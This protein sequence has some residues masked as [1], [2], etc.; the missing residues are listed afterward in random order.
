MERCKQSKKLDLFSEEQKNIYE[1]M[2]PYLNE[3]KLL[4]GEHLFLNK[5]EINDIYI[6]KTG[7]VVVYGIDK[8]FDEKIYFVLCNGSFVNEDSISQDLANTN[9][10]AFEKTTLLYI[11]K[12]KLL[13]LMQE[14]KDIMIYIMNLLSNKLSRTYRQLKN[15]S[16]TM[17]IDRRL[18]SKLWKLSSDYG[19][20]TDKGI[21]INL[22]ISAIFLAKMLGTKRETVSRNLKVLS[23]KNL[24]SIDK[25]KITIID[26]RELKYY[27]EHCKNE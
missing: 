11:N 13:K 7:K 25:N 19:L 4:K 12:N 26:E 21:L 15:S 16:T 17:K 6:V 27:I 10:R 3:K 18:A 5:D 14:D 9:C 23:D 1:K 8:N 2:S 24:I 22:D 20:Q